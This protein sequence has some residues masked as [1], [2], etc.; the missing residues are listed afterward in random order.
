MA[1]WVV[2]CRRRGA[3]S[4]LPDAVGPLRDGDKV[5]TFAT[6]AEAKADAERKR[7]GAPMSLTYWAEKLRGDDDDQ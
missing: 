4:G 1:A 3:L 6:E 7:Q 2:M 5:V